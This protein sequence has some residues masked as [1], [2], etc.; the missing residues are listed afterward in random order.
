MPLQCLSFLLYNCIV[1]F[2]TAEC[3]LLPEDH[4]LFKPWS[5]HVDKLWLQCIVHSFL[6]LLRLENFV[7]DLVN[8]DLLLCKL[9]VDGS[10]I[11]ICIPLSYGASQPSYFLPLPL[12]SV[13]RKWLPTDPLDSFICRRHS[14]ESTS[15]QHGILT[16][17]RMHKSV[18]NYLSNTKIPYLEFDELNSCGAT[19][20]AAKNMVLYLHIFYPNQ[21]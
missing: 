14:L 8:H 10:I 11:H 20:I 2:L 17:K 6:T 7:V 13:T 12:H 1:Y 9:D 3:W 15:I 21:L 18:Y 4:A 16:T 5:F 19:H